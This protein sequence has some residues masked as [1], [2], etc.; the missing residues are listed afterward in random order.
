M[1]MGEEGRETWNPYGGREEG[2]KER[3]EGAGDMV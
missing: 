3:R 2:K 1:G